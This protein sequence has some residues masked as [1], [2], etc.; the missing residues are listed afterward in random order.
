MQEY[1]C[2]EHGRFESLERRPAP[3]LLPC[4]ECALASDACIS[5]AHTMTCYATVTTGKPETKPGPL[6][7]DTLPLGEGMPAAEFR[8]K[9]RAMWQA[10]D[11]KVRKE[12]YG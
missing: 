2:P 5:A 12:R 7:L 3:R 10:H 8:K 9:R 6:A 1:E 4:P 11:R